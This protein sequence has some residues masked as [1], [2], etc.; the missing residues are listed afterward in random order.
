[1]G[2]RGGHIEVMQWARAPDPPCP[3]S[4]WTCCNAASEREPE[5][6]KWAQ[7]HG[8][9]G[10]PWDEGTCS[11]AAQGG[12]LDVLIWARE[13]DCPWD[14]RTTADAAEAG[15]TELLQWAREHGCPG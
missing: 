8:C 3:W 13:N 6:L 1:M 15:H 4:V 14:A 11:V 5:A 2:A 10:C 12:H 9:I 7:A